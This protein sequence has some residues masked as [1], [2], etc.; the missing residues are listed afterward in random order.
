M[1]VYIVKLQGRDL[2]LIMNLWSFCFSRNN[3][4]LHLCLD[5][6]QILPA[7]SWLLF[8]CCNW[9]ESGVVD[10]ILLNFNVY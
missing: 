8:L 6:V 1:K 10:V 2:V 7:I 5:N 3:P 4:Y 9:Q